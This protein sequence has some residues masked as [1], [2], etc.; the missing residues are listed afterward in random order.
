MTLVLEDPKF[1]PPPPPPILDMGCPVNPPP[2]MS[3]PSTARSISV[4]SPELAR[5]LDRLEST[6]RNARDRKRQEEVARLREL[7]RYD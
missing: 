5:E 1:P 3:T 2:V 7:A 4:E 6:E